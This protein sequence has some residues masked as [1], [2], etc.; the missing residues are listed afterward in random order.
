MEPG[1]PER[2][3]SPAI[4]SEATRSPS[5]TLPFCRSR[6]CILDTGHECQLAL[7]IAG[8]FARWP[9]APVRTRCA[10]RPGCSETFGA[11]LPLNGALPDGKSH[12]IAKLPS[13]NLSPISPYNEKRCDQR[14]DNRMTQLQKSFHSSERRHADRGRSVAVNCENPSVLRNTWVGACCL[15]IAVQAQACQ[16]H[17]DS[18]QLGNSKNTCPSIHSLAFPLYCSRSRVFKK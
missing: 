11:A 7:N 3:N 5:D 13:T 1:K 16:E 17:A 12:S 4:A 18:G 10:P 2:A 8:S 6:H 15:R 9:L 14:V